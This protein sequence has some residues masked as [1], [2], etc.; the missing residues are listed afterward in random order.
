LLIVFDNHLHLRRDG[1]FLDAV[2]DFKK[3][4][5]T[6]L[7]LC[8][9]PMVDIVVKEKSY[10]P[11]YQET[12]EMVKIIR[13]AV[14]IGVFVTVGPYPVDYIK[15]KE[16][17]GKA[18]AIQIMMDGMD[19]AADLCLD[20]KCIAIGEI[21]RPHFPVDE[22]TLDDSNEILLYGMQRAK[23]VGVPVVLHTESATP[24]LCKELVMMGK[25]AG[26]S[27]HMI[28]KHY[29][30]PL[31]RIEE[32]HGLMPSVLASEKNVV[33]S[34]EKGTRFMMETDYID[35]PK[36][37]GAVLSP[38]TVPKR[39]LDLIKKGLLTEKQAYEIHKDNPEKTYGIAL[40]G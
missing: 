4:G 16:I 30:P 22:E 34:L 32:N 27:A 23:E 7:V 6:H 12:L 20:H 38:K 14:D 5:G 13:S 36:R 31:I 24:D 9:L 25:K 17:F 15:L 8:Q 37:P 26:L 1:S 2:R 33:S 18:Q 19:L 39:T 35:D 10:K 3:A 29:S 11:C 40:D 28:V 21:G